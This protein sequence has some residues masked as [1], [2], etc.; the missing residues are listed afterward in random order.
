MAMAAKNEPRAIVVCVD[1]C[2]GGEIRGRYY[3]SSLAEEKSFRSLAQLL[4]GIEQTLELIDFPKSYTATRSFTPE[5]ERVKAAQVADTSP[6]DTM[7]WQSGT[8]ASFS[9][10]ILF[11]QNSSWQGSVLWFEGNQEQS[12]RS[13]LEL[14]F[15]MYSA[16]QQDATE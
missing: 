8:L 1:E 11:R 14:I 5:I 15:L 13:A 2:L 4:M 9:L 7:Q 6:P 16:L 3:N 12:F 10:R